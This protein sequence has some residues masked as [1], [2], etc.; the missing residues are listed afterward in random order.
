MPRADVANRERVAEPI[1]RADD[2]DLI[3]NLGLARVAEDR[4]LNTV[5]HALELEKRDV[6]TGLRCNDVRSDD[7]TSQE[8]NLDLVRDLDDMGRRHDL[9]VGRDEDA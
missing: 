7:L 3:A 6:S 1:G 5:R 9:A 4:W 8:L 2:E